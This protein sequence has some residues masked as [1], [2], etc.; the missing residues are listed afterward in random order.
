MESPAGN[1]ILS[2]T[3]WAQYRVGF[4]QPLIA[5]FQRQWHAITVPFVYNVKE[6]P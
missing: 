3:V 4:S 2:H 6:T 5:Q 1:H